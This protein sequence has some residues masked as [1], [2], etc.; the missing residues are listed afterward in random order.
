MKIQE[1]VDASMWLLVAAA[2]TQP[3]ANDLHIS[4]ETAL[5][6]IQDTTPTSKTAVELIR[7]RL[8][9]NV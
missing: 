2:S 4:I 9:K 1:L 7:S 3:D 6:R 5:Y 8:L